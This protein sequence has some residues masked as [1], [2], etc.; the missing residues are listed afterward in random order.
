MS[1][2][3]ELKGLP[4]T[5][6]AIERVG[7]KAAR[8]KYTRNALSAA[9]GVVKP[10]AAKRAPRDTGTLSKN[11]IVKTKLRMDDNGGYSIVGARRGVKV[12]VTQKK[13]GK[14]LATFRKKKDGTI[15]VTGGKRLDKA[16]AKGVKP[17]YRSPS[18]YLHLVN[19]GTKRGTRATHFM[20]SAAAA[21]QA[22]AL[23]RAMAKVKQGLEEVAKK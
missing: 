20:Q 21:K 8:K 4:E 19:Q 1:L 2:R 13:G 5:L 6:A 16:V 23:A 15:A 14:V 12:A 9:G 3:V 10:E 17:V 18:R 11:L 7:G 22:E